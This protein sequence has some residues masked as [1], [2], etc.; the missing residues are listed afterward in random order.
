[1]TKFRFRSNFRKFFQNLTKIVIFLKIWRQSKFWKIWPKSNC[2]Q[3]FDLK[4]NF[5]KFSKFLENFDQNF[6]SKFTK[7]FQFFPKFR[8]I[9]ISVK[10]SNNFDFGQIF[11]KFRYF[12][13][14]SK[15]YALFEIFEI[16]RFRSH[17]RKKSSLVKI[18][19]QIEFYENC[20]FGPNFQK[21]S[22]LAKF[23]KKKL[24]LV[25]FSIKK[26]DFGQTCD[27]FRFLSKFS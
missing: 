16:F 6:W 21:F 14:F 25:K 10:S 23:L 27:K 18:S 20:D 12:S 3:K 9:S 1:M 7:N 11:E 13:K 26:I 17:F 2:F 22:I 5:S 19:N 24:V 8:K 15:M 4:W